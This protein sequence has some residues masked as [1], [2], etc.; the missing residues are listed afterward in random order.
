MLVRDRIALERRKQGISAQ[1]LAD[2]AGVNKG[3]ISRY[4]NGYVKVIPTQVLEKIAAAIHVPFDE[5]VIDDPKY[6]ALA[7]DETVRK[8]ASTLTSDEKELLA[9]YRGL[10]PEAQGIMRQIWNLEQKS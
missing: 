9:W 3:S 4:E 1:Q 7:S 6:A 8:S 2:A 5:L 10:T